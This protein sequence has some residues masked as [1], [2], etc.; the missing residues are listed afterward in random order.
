[1]EAGRETPVDLRG[2]GQGKDGAEAD[3]H[4]GAV[5]FEDGDRLVAIHGNQNRGDD[6]NQ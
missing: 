3:K 1:M 4:K 2:K 6:D 5:L